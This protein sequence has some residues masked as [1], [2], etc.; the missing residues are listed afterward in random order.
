MKR[1]TSLA[2]F[3]LLFYFIL[4]FC[5]DD[6]LYKDLYF[7]YIFIGNKRQS[8]G[9]NGEPRVNW[10]PWSCSDIFC[11]HNISSTKSITNQSLSITAILSCHATRKSGTLKDETAVSGGRPIPYELDQP[12]IVSS[13]KVS[14]LKGTK[15]ALRD[16]T[17]SCCTG[18]TCQHNVNII[19]QNH[20]TVIRVY[21]WPCHATEV[22][23]KG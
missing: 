14:P 1:V 16:K 10:F 18:L 6:R 8:D 4:F 19:I 5:W 20:D 2:C 12:I 23:T 3:F 11:I 13:R 15:E 21:Y 7:D 9:I 17:K 22:A